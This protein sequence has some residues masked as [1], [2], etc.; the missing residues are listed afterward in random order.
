MIR[1][2]RIGKMY[3]LI[4][5]TKLLRIL[6]IIKKKSKIAKILTNYI[7]IGKGVERIVFGMLGFIV[8]VHIVSCLWIFLGNFD[9]IG[10]WLDNSEIDNMS[11]SEIYL[12][13]FYFTTTTITTVGY[14]DI[15]GSTM[16]EKIYCIL[17]MIIGVVAFSFA[18]ASLTSLF[19]N[20]DSS[21]A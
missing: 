19:S 13:S 14:G 2:V 9:F 10:S 6:K 4:K 18:S 12:T 20:I 3:K 11:G 16:I 21:N 7:A 5:L 1:I 17:I 15:S 8:I